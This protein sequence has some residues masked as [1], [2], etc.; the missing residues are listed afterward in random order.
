M[1]WLVGGSGMLGREVAESL[2]ARKAELRVTASQDMDITD[3]ESVTRYA[4][5]HRPAWIVNCAAYTA[6]DQAES[7]EERAHAVNAMGAGHLAQAANDVGARLLHVSTDYVFDGDHAA[8]YDEDAT[9]NPVGAYGRSKATGESNVR[10]G[11]AR[12]FIVRTAWLHG[13]HGGNFVRTMLRLMAERSELRVVA[14]QRGSPTYAA[15]LAEALVAFVEQD[16]EAYGT[17]HYTNEGSCTW[18]E[19]ALEI[20]DQA[21]AR[22]LLS[23]ST[24]VDPIA[25]EDYPTPAR[26]PANSTLATGRIRAT[27][28]VSIPTWQ[29]GVGRHLD[30]LTRNGI[31]R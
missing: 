21:V 16:A 9:P 11:C 6:V 25:T 14:D 7:E 27:L 17:Y 20:R 12:S 3:A 22:G 8:P 26:R 24:P 23:E 1:I 19:F 2:S 10:Q 29:D 5:E 4:S 31:Q 15:D 18:H 13:P 28:G 30:R